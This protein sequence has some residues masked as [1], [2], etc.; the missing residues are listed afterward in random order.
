MVGV[1]L[2]TIGTSVMTNTKTDTSVK[3]GGVTYG[4]GTI[5]A[6][7]ISWSAN[8]AI[9]WAMLHGLFSWL[10]VIYYMMTSDG[11]SWL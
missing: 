3:A 11:W 7:T 10:Y 5:L 4:L 9:L 8:K 6:V 1:S 2:K